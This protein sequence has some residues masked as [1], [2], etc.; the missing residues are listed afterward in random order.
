MV[1]KYFNMCT[2]VIITL[3]RYQ[4]ITLSNYHVIKLSSY[5]VFNL[6][7]RAFKIK[8]KLLGSS[9]VYGSLW[10]SHNRSAI[11]IFWTGQDGDL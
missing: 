7:S 10:I 8:C 5:Q 2:S 4:A 1:A 11:W 9:L 6:L 3:S